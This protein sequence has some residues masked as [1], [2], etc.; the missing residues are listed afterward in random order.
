MNHAH[1]IY[2]ERRD[3]VLK[4]M[5]NHAGG[6]VALIPTAPEVPRNRDSNFPYRHDSY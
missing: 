1:H 2:R 4:T 6:G 5:R 3:A